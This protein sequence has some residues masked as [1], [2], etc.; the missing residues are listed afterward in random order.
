MTLALPTR[1][2][3]LRQSAAAAFPAILRAK[4]ARKP[5]I[6][7]CISDDQS[8]I[9]TGF[10]GSKFVKTPAFDRVAGEGV[11]FRN[12]FVSAPSCAPSRASVLT[13]QDFYRLRTASMNHV[14]WP[15]DTKTWPDLLAEA[16][17]HTGFTGKGW[18]PGNWKASGRAT[19]PCGPAFNQVQLKPPS[20]GLSPIDY[21]RNF[22][23]FLAR[24]PKDAPYGFWVGFNE[25]HR[26]F[27]PGV[28]LRSGK[29]LDDVE[30]PAFLPDT[31]EV[32]S[33]LADYAFEI[34]W[35]D[36]QMARILATLEKTGELTNTVVVMTSDNGMAFPS[37]KGNLYDYGAH[38]PLAIRWPD[39]S[40][41]HRKVEDFVTTADF[42][43]TLLWAAGLP[44]PETMTGRTVRRALTARRSS[45]ID[46]RR[47]YAVTG[48]ERHFPGSRPAGAGY[49]SRAIR[50]ADYLYIWNLTPDRNPAGDH[51]GPTWPTDDPTGGFGDIDG[52]PTKTLL[53]QSRGKYPDL[54]RRAFDPRPSEELYLVKKDP[55]NLDN[56]IKAPLHAEAGRMLRGQ[57]MAHLET[58]Q[59]PRVT[60]R[61]RELDAIMQKFPS[62]APEVSAAETQ[63]D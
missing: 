46:A 58:T 31:P 6:L 63:R 61:G 5:N 52:S 8:W 39:G 45:I 50:T 53:W 62:V 26:V 2:S 23:A 55:S 3:V 21:A 34:E 28:G 43:P 40:H 18:G 20:S 24:R 9:H 17:Y 36:R 12:C 59:D 44:V 38:V 41:G 27:D 33:D 32:R 4:S 19:S 25:P 48:I 15:R 13:G 60:G 47:S 51:P 57:L 35:Y 30:V 56:L 29:R 22:E 14:E 16:G 49:P 1:R 10:A 37:A 54:A 11:Y 7:F 42:A